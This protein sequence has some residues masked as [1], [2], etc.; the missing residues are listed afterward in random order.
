TYFVI[1]DER[2]ND[3]D[4]I[5]AGRINLLFGFAAARPGDFQAWLV[6]HQ[7]GSSRVRHVSV[8]RMAT[9][10]R[11][12]EWEIETAILRGLVLEH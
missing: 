11:R 10:Q 5:A 4:S 8:N 9:S 7:P 2:I 1:C 6:S 12:L 3:A